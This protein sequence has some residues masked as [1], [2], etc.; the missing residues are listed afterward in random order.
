MSTVLALETSCDESAAA[1]VRDRRVLASAVASQIEEHARWGGVVPEIASRRHVEALPGLIERVVAESGVG[2]DQLD[3]I[4]ATVAPGLVG[5]LLVGSVTART[6]AH[7]HG[8][9]FLGVHHLEGHLCSAGLGEALPPGPCLVLLVSGGHT[10]LVRVEG[11]GLYRRLG[12]SHDDA[13]GECFDKVARLLGLSYPG[14]PAIE[15]AAAGGDPRSFAL[16]KGRVSRPE[17]GFH[18][19]DFSFSGLKTAVLRHVQTLE[20]R[21]QPLPLADLAASFE[22]V[23]AEVLVERSC[24]CAV[25][26]GLDTLVLV[27]GVA[28]N[29]RLRSLLERQAAVAGLQ[30]RVAPLAYCTDNAAMIGLAATQRLQVGACSSTALGVAPRLP[31]EEAGRLYETLPCF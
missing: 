11:P 6:L 17:G 19:Y 16:P 31:L 5:A 13:A 27:G 22:Q 7:L 20:Q 3:G 29:R 21:G 26:E 1:I 23:V 9:P 24:R 30:W 4:A 25:D 28:A 14:G 10:E 2:L 8:K 12:R 15:A 18:P